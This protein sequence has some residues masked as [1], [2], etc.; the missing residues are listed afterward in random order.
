[1]AGKEWQ[2]GGT[3]TT[4]YGVFDQLRKRV[5]A[6]LV[7]YLMTYA[8]SQDAVTLEAGSGPAFASSMM[9]KSSKVDF[10][11]ALDIDLEA[12]EEARKRDKTLS[13]VV[14][15]LEHLPI[16]T[17]CIDLVW[18]SSTLEHLPAPEAALDEMVRVTKN[19]GKVFV[20]IPNVCGPL[21]FERLIRETSVGIWIG[22][23]FSLGGLKKLL[24]EAGLIPERHLHY[25][26]RFFVGVIAHKK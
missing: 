11:I 26:F 20:G 5:N 7:N 10:S 12:L 24:E 13:L 16:R 1:M 4:V 23:T 17:D 15:D 3:E 6:N 18:N 21:G 19:K 25:F 8:V 22:K 2:L 9:N 14:A